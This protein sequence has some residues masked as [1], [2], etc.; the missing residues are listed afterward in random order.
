MA[1]KQSFL[2]VINASNSKIT[3][4]YVTE[5]V[6]IIMCHVKVYVLMKMVFGSVMGSASS[7]TN[8][9]MVNAMVQMNGHVTTNV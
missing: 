2:P 9:A 7:L 4:V 5:N 1:D 3:H 6:S 8:N